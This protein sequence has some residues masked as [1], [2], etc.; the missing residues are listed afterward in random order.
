MDT[1][2]ST[3]QTDRLET[4]ARCDGD[5]VTAAKPDRVQDQGNPFHF[6]DSLAGHVGVLDATGRLVHINRRWR[7]YALANGYKNRNN[8]SMF[9]LGV[10]YL[11]LCDSATGKD[12][13]D[14]RNV[15][16]GIRSVIEGENTEF[17]YEYPCHAPDEKHWFKV[18]VR[19]LRKTDETEN[20]ILIQHI[21]VTKQVTGRLGAEEAARNYQ[22]SMAGFIEALPVQVASISDD[23]YYRFANS[24]F[25]ERVGMEKDQIRGKRPVDVVGLKAWN[26]LSPYV[27]RALNGERVTFEADLTLQTGIRLQ[28]IVTYIPDRL[29]SGEVIG[30]IAFI[31]DVSELKRRQQ[32]LYLAM[33]AAEQANQAKSQF[34]ASMSHELRTPLNAIIGF[35]EMIALGIADA[36]NTEKNSEYARDILASARHLLSMVEDIL[37][38]SAIE[39]GKVT[40]A[41]KPLDLMAIVAEC[42]R[43]VSQQ[44]EGKH[45]I[46]LVEKPD[47]H[48]RLMADERAVRQVLLNILSNAVKYTP[49][50]GGVVVDVEANATEVEVKVIDTGIGISPERLDEV[51][52]AFN[53]S[54]KEP[55]I[56]EKGWGLGLSISKS[57]V[58]L[59][60]G[61]LEIVSEVDK[62]T[63]VTVTLPRGDLPPD[64]R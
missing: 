46:L 38:L 5:C 48:I 41:K 56:A 24:R 31:Q 13:P 42:E 50:Y 43:A 28:A 44:V 10:N 62:G 23:L 15:A 22:T 37:D 59:H 19:P 21:D 18:F 32:H 7:A 29:P 36:A 55:Y 4:P 61:R 40:I 63:T 14:A 47:A 51:T 30:F 16:A 54:G 9:G 8:N 57:L 35:A 33:Q 39:G 1:A 53:R 25:A 20:R 52:D 64:G 34:L 45:Q 27:S 17:S 12:S 26:V 60:G 49:D 58:E 3:V 2:S 11:T 6:L